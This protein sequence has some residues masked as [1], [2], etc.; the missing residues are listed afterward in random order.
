MFIGRCSFC[1]SEIINGFCGICG[2]NRAETEP[3]TRA[4]SKLMDVANALS[5]RDTESIM[6]NVIENIENQFSTNTSPELEYWLGIAWE[7]FAGWYIRGDERKAYL[8]KSIKHYEKGYSLGR[9][10]THKRWIEYA[11]NLG[12]LLVDTAIIR[13]IEKAIPIL[14]DIYNNTDDYFPSLCSLPEAYYKQ[15][16]YL[17]AAEL[18]KSVYERGVKQAEKEFGTAEMAPPAALD[19]ATK[20]YRALVRQYKKDG[21]IES[22]YNISCKLIELDFY[23]DNDEKTHN[24]LEEEKER[25]AGK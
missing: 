6:K 4:I 12:R 1:G 21:D 14:E 15:G 7:N 13:D 22:A 11:G 23:S 20:A 19:T 16:E 10:Y 5:E 17:R 2:K 18:G 25:S 9:D 3:L 24:K 8:K